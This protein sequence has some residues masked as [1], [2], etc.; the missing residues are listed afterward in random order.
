MVVVAMVGRRVVV[1]MARNSPRRGWLLPL[2][3]RLMTATAPNPVPVAAVTVAVPVR[4]MEMTTTAMAD[5]HDDLAAPNDAARASPITSVTACQPWVWKRARGAIA[6]MSIVHDT[7]V[8]GTMTMAAAIDALATV[9]R[10]V[11]LGLRVVRVMIPGGR[12]GVMEEM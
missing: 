1:A 5:H 6:T 3:R 7:V 10:I 4:E 2:V 12:D 9:T 8:T 11:I